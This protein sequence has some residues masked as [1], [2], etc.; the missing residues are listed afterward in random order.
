[1]SKPTKE[2]ADAVAYVDHVITD[3]MDK[4]PGHGLTPISLRPVVFGDE[5]EP[6]FVVRVGGLDDSSSETHGLYLPEDGTEAPTGLLAR[7]LHAVA[8][9]V[10]QMRIHASEGDPWALP[11]DDPPTVTIDGDV[12]KGAGVVV[13][14]NSVTI[15][16]NPVEVVQSK[17]GEPELMIRQTVVSNGVGVDI[18]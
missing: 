14:G 4:I 18:G 12:H 9:T 17:P 3:L 6:C 8:R 16:G 11:V 13:R 10:F 1:M 2:L 5:T 15:D 7:Q